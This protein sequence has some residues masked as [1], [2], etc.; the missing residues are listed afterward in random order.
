[1][2]ST[3]VELDMDS[4]G[5]R[6]KARRKELGLSQSAVG[7]LAGGISYQAV[8]QI[9]GGGESKH[10]VAIAKALRVWPEWLQSGNGPKEQGSV[11]QFTKQSDDGNADK[12]TH[13]SSGQKYGSQETLKVLGMAEG[14]PDGWSLWNGDVIETIRRPDN[15][16]GV[17]GAYAVYVIGHSM[18]PRYNQGE[19]AHIHPH[20]PLEPGC[21][22]LVQRKPIDGY[23][24]PLAIVKR[25]VRRSGSK[26][27]LEQLNPPKTFEVKS[28]EIVSIHRVVGAS[29]A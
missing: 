22:V 26:I 19:H 7:K 14:G 28:D 18:E 10:L 13:Q 17:E 27:V 11:N 20:K 16:I 6:V 29:E 2:T 23:S 21:Y 12:L 5:E 3:L 25:L 24:T 1:M 9:E 8:Q 15:L 4:I